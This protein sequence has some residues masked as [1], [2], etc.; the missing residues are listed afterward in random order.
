MGA[1]QFGNARLT[2][3]KNATKTKFSNN[4]FINNKE[5]QD[6]VFNWHKKDIESNITN[7][8]FDKY[9]G[10]NILDIPVT[11][12]GLIAVAHLGGKEGMKKF[13]E[14]GGKYN[15]ADS[16]G[17]TLSNYLDKFKDSS[18]ENN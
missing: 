14:S 16:N 11:Q 12:S 18:N 17:T 13:L 9:I 8:G 6:K 2:D 1:Y 15:P 10:T 3:Y 4:D 5:L 7:S